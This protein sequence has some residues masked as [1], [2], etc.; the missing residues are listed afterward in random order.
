MSKYNLIM[1]WVL[2]DGGSTTCFAAT[3]SM[4]F[5]DRFKHSLRT[6]CSSLGLIAGSHMLAYGQGKPGKQC[7]TCKRMKPK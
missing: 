7:L 3:L 6:A 2:E 4:H 5:H 1:T